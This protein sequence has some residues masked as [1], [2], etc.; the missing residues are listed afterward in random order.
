M[1]DYT[2]HNGYFAKEWVLA[3]SFYWASEGLD[4]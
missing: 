1:L 2:K 4:G 3:H